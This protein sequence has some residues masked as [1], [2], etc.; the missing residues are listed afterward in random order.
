MSVAAGT[1]ASRGMQTIS[2]VLGVLT[3]FYGLLVLSLRPVALASIAV[4]AALALF[5]AGVGQ[6]VL[7]QGVPGGWKWLGYAAGLAVIIAG[8]LALVWPGATLFVLAILLAWS[9]VIH[10][11]VRII[12]SLVT[13]RDMW[14]FALIVGILEVLIGVWAIGSPGREVLLLVN[15]VGIFLI[16][17]GVDAVVTAFSR[18]AAGER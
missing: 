9:F 11:L 3:V 8:I 13:R 12:G 5:A 1:H 15:L 14:W 4:L 17:A 2:V 16:F 7:A 10:G 18:P 6:I